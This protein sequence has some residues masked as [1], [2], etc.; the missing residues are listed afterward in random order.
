MR[1][2]LKRFILDVGNRSLAN[3]SQRKVDLFGVFEAFSHISWLSSADEVAPLFLFRC[4]FFRGYFLFEK[5]K[6]IKDFMEEIFE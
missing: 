3:N 5:K 2:E 4:S 1:F 6:D